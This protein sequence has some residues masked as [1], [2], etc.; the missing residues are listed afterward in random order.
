MRIFLLALFLAVG[1]GYGSEKKKEE[2]KADLSDLLPMVRQQQS[3]YLG[4]SL[5]KTDEY[6]WDVNSKC[7]GL[8]FNSLWAIAG[9]PVDIEKARDSEGKWYRHA[10]QSCYEDGG[11]TSEISRDMILGLLLYVWEYKRLDILQSL[12]KYGESHN[13]RMGEGDKTKTGIRLNLKATIYELQYRLGGGDSY[14][15][16]WPQSWDEPVPFSLAI[17]NPGYQTH[18]QVL[19]IYLRA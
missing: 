18:L 8:L 4:L 14:H 10:S 2:K 3:T 19:H 16:H 11:A 6:G 13:W 17:M 1:C 12:I 15:R 9:A 7:D 5:E